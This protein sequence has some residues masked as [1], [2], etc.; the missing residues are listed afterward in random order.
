MG[1]GRKRKA[2]SS[3]T[4]SASSARA[5]NDDDDDDTTQHSRRRQRLTSS[6][7]RSQ[8]QK[9]SDN[10]WGGSGSSSGRRRGGSTRGAS[11]RSSGT[12]NSVPAINEAAATKMF[13][14]IADND[15]PYVASMEGISTLCE[16]LGIDPMEDVRILVLMWKMG[17]NKTPAQINK[18]EWIQGCTK[19]QVDSIDKIKALL[20]SLDTG[21]LDQTEFKDFFKVRTQ[22]CF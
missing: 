3:T 17:A 19:L 16:D 12:T 5:H 14:K 2:S 22:G 1:G 4:S 7:S 9:T 10:M 20:P 13:T 11:Y 15:D 6:V 21:F 18:D 8:E